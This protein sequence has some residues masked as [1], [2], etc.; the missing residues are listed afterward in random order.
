MLAQARAGAKDADPMAAARL[1]REMIHHLVHNLTM[2]RLGEDAAGFILREQHQP[3][4]AFDILYQRL[5]LPIQQ[6]YQL[7]VSRIL[8]NSHSNRRQIMITHA[9]R[10][11][12]AAIV[13]PFQYTSILWGLVFGY[14]V[15]GDLPDA[16]MLIGAAI[17]VASGLYILYRETRHPPAAASAT[18]KT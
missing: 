5:M 12:P 9:F 15:F 18:S 6:T 7:L 11:A 10:S 13:S 4:P 16:I 2:D 8:G 3:T 17:V 1:L 14:A